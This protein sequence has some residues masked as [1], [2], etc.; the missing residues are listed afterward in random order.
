MHSVHWAVAVAAREEL[1]ALNG[2]GHDVADQWVFL[3]QIRR[4]IHFLPLKLLADT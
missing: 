3:G 4:E 1:L 2:T